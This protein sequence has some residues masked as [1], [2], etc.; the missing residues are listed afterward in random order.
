MVCLCINLVL[1][2]LVAFLSWFVHFN[3]FMNSILKTC[4]SSILKLLHVPL[5]FMHGIGECTQGF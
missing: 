4:F 2:V 1:N 5:V 3:M